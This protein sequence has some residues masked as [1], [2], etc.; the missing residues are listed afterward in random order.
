[1]PGTQDPSPLGRDSP[2]IIVDDGTLPRT[3]TPAAGP[4]G[5]SPAEA[6]PADAR[7]SRGSLGTQI[8]QFAQNRLGRRVGDG[9]CFALADQA[10]RGAGAK[11]AADFGSVSA[12]ADYVWGTAVSLTNVQPGDIVQFRDYQYTR[13][14]DDDD[15]AW[16]E[17]SES[18]PHHTAIVVSNDGNGQLTLIEQNAPPGSAARRIQMPFSSDTT[19]RGATSVRV[20]VTGQVWFYRPQAR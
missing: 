14:E 10:L 18:R 11:S 3:R 4:I 8:V 7:G 15:G 16:R 6:E 17:N 13:R 9:E 2:S 1:M 12:E 5:V 19:R 20:T